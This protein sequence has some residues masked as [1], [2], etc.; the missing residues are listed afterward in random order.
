M[1]RL[2]IDK[3]NELSSAAGP[4]TRKPDQREKAVTNNGR[5][6][7]AIDNGD[8]IVTAEITPKLTADGSELLAQAQPLK[9]RVHAV[10]VTDGAG[11]R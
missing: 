10:N 2:D 8:F 5:L 9:G 11:A 4:Q 1:C 6:K 3:G 7:T